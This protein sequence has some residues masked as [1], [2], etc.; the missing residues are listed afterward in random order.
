MDQFSRVQFG[1]LK[2]R[3]RGW[4]Y[5]QRYEYLCAITLCKIIFSNILKSHSFFLSKPEHGHT[6]DCVRLYNIRWRD[7]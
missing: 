7:I 3:I 6:T 2:L 1:R 4:N 5:N